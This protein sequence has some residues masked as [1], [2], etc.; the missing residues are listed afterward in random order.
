MRSTTVSSHLATQNPRQAPCLRYSDPAGSF[1]LPHL[2]EPL[3][4]LAHGWN[5]SKERGAW[6]GSLITETKEK[7]NRKGIIRGL[8]RG[9]RVCVHVGVLVL[10]RFNN[11]S[12]FIK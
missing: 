4:N 12:E 2:S 9:G 10:L 11:I 6:I 3:T 1:D 7:W 8:T 5:R